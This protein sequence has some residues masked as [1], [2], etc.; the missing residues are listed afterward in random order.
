[1]KEKRDEDKSISACFLRRKDGF[2]IFFGDEN[3]ID[4]GSE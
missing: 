4:V 1:M 3:R 2:E